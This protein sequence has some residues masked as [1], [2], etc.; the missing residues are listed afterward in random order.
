ME[1]KK[2]EDLWGTHIAVYT[3]E[4]DY[5]VN[6]E[7]DEIKDEEDLKIKVQARIN[8]EKGEDNKRKEKKQKIRQFKNIKNLKI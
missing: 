1:I 6:F 8:L 4:L 7:A 5:G 2:I 3:D